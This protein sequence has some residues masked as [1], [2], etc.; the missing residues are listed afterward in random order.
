MSFEIPVK[1]MFGVGQEKRRLAEGL[2]SPDDDKEYGRFLEG[3]SGGFMDDVHETVK[4]QLL[5][6]YV[7]K[8]PGHRHYPYVMSLPKKYTTVG[9]T[10]RAE[11]VGK[12]R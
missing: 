5:L 12:L 1:N 4:L 8:R 11:D 7:A 2:S 3:L 10:W 9:A 6:C